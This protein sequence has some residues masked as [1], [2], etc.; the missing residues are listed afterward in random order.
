VTVQGRPPTSAEQQRRTRAGKHGQTGKLN[1][2]WEETRNGVPG[3]TPYEYHGYGK[4]ED[5]IGSP[6]R[7]NKISKQRHAL[8]I[9][10][11]QSETECPGCGY[12]TS[13]CGCPGSTAR[14]AR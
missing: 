1:P 13:W 10:A 12:L 3:F 7:A 8:R 11:R 14:S 6:A 9:A 2:I 5:V 4:P